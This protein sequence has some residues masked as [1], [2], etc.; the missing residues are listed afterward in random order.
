MNKTWRDISTLYQIYPR[1]FQ[2]SNGDGV[3]DINGII[4]RLDYLGRVLGIEAIWI[5]PFFVS[6]MDDFGYDVADYYD[7]DPSYGSLRD[8]KRLLDEAHRRGIK[9]MIDLVP[10][11]TSDQHTWFQESK[12]SKNNPK[13]DYYIWRDPQPDGSPPNNWLSQSGGSAWE[14]DK[15][16]GQ[17]YLHSFLKTQPD[18]NWDNPEVRREIQD[19]L[20]WWFNFGVDGARVD[21][22]WSISKD[23]QLRN[24]KLNPGFE[25]S[26][27]EYGYYIHNHSKN[28]PNMEFYLQEIAAVAEEFEDRQLIFEYY[29]DH[30]LGDIFSQYKLV[31]E[32]NPRVASAFFME[33]IRNNWHAQDM[34]WNLDDYLNRSLKHSIPV[35]SVGN[36]DQPRIF[37]RLGEKRARAM[38]VL[39]FALPGISMIYNGDEIGMTN[40]DLSGVASK[41]KF[42]PL[43]SED[44]RDQARTP[45]QWNSLDFA[46][47]S[48]V[49]PWLPV[50]SNKEFI[51]VAS[52]L[53]QPGS[54]LKLH[55]K[56]IALRKQ[57][58]TLREGSFELIN[59]ENGYLLGFK[60]EFYGQKIYV[61]VNFADQPQPLELPEGCQ[62]IL[63]SDDSTALAKNHIDA[64]QAQIYLAPKA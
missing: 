12:S 40:S 29:P 21:A 22:V 13:R 26:S 14:F 8:F 25:G 27:D 17:Y 20:R 48:S 59:L 38:T 39:N 9:V 41:D 51:N 61:V 6:P 50:N 53:N 42:S 10:C 60:R 31:A 64:H 23:P 58:S 30:Q 33:L 5:S 16:T 63:S 46:G 45:L 28:G 56:L 4:S 36:H 7:I 2:D 57:Y 3:G 52:Q 34:A 15:T 37:G 54:A 44:S 11:H 32:A 62:L 24:N 43:S 49:E 18:L 55:Q 35:F 47:F 1:S 19:V